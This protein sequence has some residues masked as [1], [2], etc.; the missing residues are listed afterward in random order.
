LDS[1]FYIETIGFLAVFF[2]ALLGTPQFLRNYRLKSTEGMSVK[3]VLMWTSGDIFKTVYFLVRHAP[4]QF[5]LCGAL[6]I[7][8]DIA[9]LCQVMIYSNNN[10]PRKP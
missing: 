2:E 10:H 4:A 3:M 5:W 7:S 8:I 6:Q 1:T 9:I